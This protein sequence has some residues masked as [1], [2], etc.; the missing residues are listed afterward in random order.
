MPWDLVYFGE[1]QCTPPPVVPCAIMLLITPVPVDRCHD[2]LAIFV[3]YT[4]TFQLQEHAQQTDYALL[5]WDQG[6]ACLRP[7][8]PMRYQVLLLP[9][10]APGGQHSSAAQILRC[11]HLSRSKHPQMLRLVLGDEIVRDNSA[12]LPSHNLKPVIS[13]YAS[14]CKVLCTANCV[15]GQPRRAVEDVGVQRTLT[16]AVGGWA[17]HT[18]LPATR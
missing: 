6:F 9:C 5:D 17:A 12:W 15:H 2:V 11:A 13:W 1:Q 7:A 16:K 8:G 3:H 14:R 4:G 18:S 10:I